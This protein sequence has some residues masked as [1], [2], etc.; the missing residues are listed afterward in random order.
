MNT[1]ATTTTPSAPAEKGAWATANERARTRHEQALIAKVKGQN[2]VNAIANAYEKQ[3]IEAFRPFLGTKILTHG[4]LAARVKP[5][6]PEAPD[7]RCWR[8]PSTHSLYY[9]MDVTESIGEYGCTY[10]KATV[11]VGDL[12]GYNLAKVLEPQPPRRTDYTVEEIVELRKSL[13]VAR[14]A[15]SAIQSKLATFGEYDQ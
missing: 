4:G 6:I 7:A 12:D 13:R 11:Y 14:D 1:E 5:H 3:L 9:E 8:A 10:C 2:K 15:V